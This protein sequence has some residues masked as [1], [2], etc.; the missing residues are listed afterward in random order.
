MRLPKRR[1]VLASVVFLSVCV[2]AI[3]ATVVLVKR[4]DLPGEP[5]EIRGDEIE[6]PSEAEIPFA[7]VPTE[8]TSAG[9]AGVDGTSEPAATGVSTPDPTTSPT[10]EP[11]Q[12]ARDSWAETLFYIIADVP[13]TD[14]E[15]EEMPGLVAAIP[16]EAAFAVHLGDI[17]N[18]VDS[19]TESRIQEFVGFVRE[20]AVPMFV[21]VGDNEYND[22]SDPVAALDIWRSQLVRFDNIHWN[23]SLP[24]KTM[25]NRPESFYF[26]NNGTLFIG[27][28]LVG[29]PSFNSSEWGERLDTQVAWTIKLI[30]EHRTGANEVGAV[31]I[32]GHASPN[33]EH[34]P[35][36]IKLRDYIRDVLQNSMPIL[37]LCGDVHTYLYEEN[38]EDQPSWLRVRKQGGTNDPPLKVV[39]KPAKTPGANDSIQE[40]FNVTRFW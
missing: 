19:C 21:V 8:G 30:D 2:A 32:F 13:Y 7:D 27:L 6:T 34:D 35:F 14:N 29:T 26:E 37:Y 28:N 11:T 36:F 15:R 39:V 23:H 17:K 4:R 38:Y 10:P 3:I 1:V 33:G 18:A 12:N 16:E 22:C 9:E 25:E 20:S 31:V 40:V 5:T 24:V